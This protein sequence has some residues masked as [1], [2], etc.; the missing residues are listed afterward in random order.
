MF[1]KSQKALFLAVVISLVVANPSPQIENLAD[2]QASAN[3]SAAVGFNGAQAN[4][5]QP[6]DQNMNRVRSAAQAEDSATQNSLAMS[7]VTP[8]DQNPPTPEKSNKFAQA[9]KDGIHKLEQYYQNSKATSEQNS[10]EMPSSGGA[11]NFFRSVAADLEK[12]QG[13]RGG[14]FQDH[15]F[16]W[17]YSCP[18]SFCV[19]YL[20]III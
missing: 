2:I 16:F 10:K 12:F 4:A 18:C 9:I 7:S 15:K 6:M 5:Q 13:W 11:G 20:L 14:W 8:Q 3:A 1:S 17:L 19:V